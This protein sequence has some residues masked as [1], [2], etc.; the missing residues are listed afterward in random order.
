[1]PGH[2]RRLVEWLAREVRTG[3]R[4]T[5]EALGQVAFRPQLAGQLQRLIA[6]DLA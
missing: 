5:G 3:E 6:R 2:D 4:G 1:M